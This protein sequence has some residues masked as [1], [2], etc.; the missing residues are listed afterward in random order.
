MATERMSATLSDDFGSKR[1][2]QPQAADDGVPNQRW[3]E[4]YQELQTL[5]SLTSV[6]NNPSQ[7]KPPTSITELWEVVREGV[8]ELTADQSG[9]KDGKGA[10]APTESLLGPIPDISDFQSYIDTF[11]DFW[12]VY[13]RNHRVANKRRTGGTFLGKDGTAENG[14]RCE[15]PE[16]VPSEYGSSDFK[17]EQHQL[18]KQPL[19]TSVERQDELNAELSSHLDTIEVALFEHIRKAQ[20]EQL[21]DSV[22]KMGE[23]L[24][25]D[26]RST[27]TVVTSLRSRL[28]SVQKRQLQC[29]MTVGRLARRKE[30]V[31]EVL[32]R[33][34]CLAHVHQ[35]PPTIQMLLQG[36]DYVTALDLLESTRIALESNLRG[37]VSMEQGAT[38]L[39]NLGRDFN[40]TLE[41]DFVHC[42]STAILGSMEAGGMGGARQEVVPNADRLRSLSW[43]LGKRE[44]LKTTLAANLRDVLLSLLKKALKNQT[45]SQLEALAKEEAATR[46]REQQAAVAQ[47][48]AEGSASAGEGGGEAGEGGQEGGGEQAAE[49]EKRTVSDSTLMITGTLTALSFDGFVTFWTR[50]MQTSIE[51]AERYCSYAALVQQVVVA[52]REEAA[53][54]PPVAAS[55]SYRPGRSDDDVSYEILRLYEVLMNNFLQKMGVLLEARQKEHRTLKTADWQV[56][57]KVSNDGL[58]KIKSLQ[59]QCRQTALPQSEAGSG[60]DIGASLRGILYSQT[61]SIIKEYHEQRLAKMKC[62]LENERWERADVPMPYKRILDKL[63]AQQED[64]PPEVTEGQDVERYLRVDGQNYLVVPAVLELLQLLSEYAQM[65]RDF[66]S[67]AAEILQRMAELLKLFNQQS[68]KLVLGG[69]AVQRQIMKKV[70]A[71]NLALCSQCCA[72]VADVL[73][74]LQARLQ[75]MLGSG[76]AGGRNA[77]AMMLADLSKIAGEYTE[78]RQALF[79]KLS[80]LLRERYE[81]HS[82]K[83]FGA[84]HSDIGTAPIPWLTSG[85]EAVTVKPEELNPHEALDGLVK[86]ISSMYRVLLKNL[87]GESVRGIFSKA[88]QDIGEKFEARMDGELTAPSPPYNPQVGHSLGDRF[89]MDVAFLQ[90]QLGNLTGISQPL[91]KLLHNFISHLQVKLPPDDN[92]K[93]VNSIVVAVLQRSNQLPR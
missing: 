36:K 9:Q 89:V 24:R 76:S 90:D 87:S 45:K 57:L 51:V 44:L 19:Q 26:L 73:P 35:S 38:R 79:D 75:S 40:R 30:R 60:A 31:A 56:L 82:K 65:C 68:Q 48:P 72:L 66:Q 42:S 2:Q 92:L 39:S 63:V 33:L 16:S 55:A 14:N 23:P 43:C 7:N 85:G 84:A 64:A 29:G 46:E 78:H 53:Q 1:Q 41:V 50:T 49:P 58:D 62:V 47:A 93:R 17:L 27:V 4:V 71:A 21:F 5:Q 67:L 74:K 37:L 11:A 15:L 32:Q 88:F 77:G 8:E 54:E 70:T 12:E 10:E 69:N 80:M 61:Q 22:A 25:D 28:K 86:D 6:I 81:F 18:F 52:L 91:A 20:R 13:A 3:S 34:D 83:W 59:E